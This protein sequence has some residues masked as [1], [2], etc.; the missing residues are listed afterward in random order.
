MP[1][2][3][4]EKNYDDNGNAAHYKTQRLDSLI[5]FER[6]WGTEAVMLFCEINALKYRLRLGHKEAPLEQELKKARWYEIQAKRFFEKL[7]TKEEIKID[8]RVKIENNV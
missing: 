6:T 2:K 3:A 8:N 5:V 1:D 4:N 7:N